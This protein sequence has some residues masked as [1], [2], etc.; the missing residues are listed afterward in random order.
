MSITQETMVHHQSYFKNSGVDRGG[1][2]GQETPAQKAGRCPFSYVGSQQ[3]LL[4]S[5]SKVS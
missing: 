4:C 1:A 3:T 2:T 5:L